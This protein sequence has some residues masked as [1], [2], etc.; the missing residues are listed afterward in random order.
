MM[1]L[2]ASFAEAF[3]IA[4]AS[5]RASKLRSF[6]TLLGIILSTTTLI[7]VM[8]VIHGMNRYVAEKIADLG[9]GGFVVVRMAFFG[10]FD[11]KKFLEMLRKN[12]QLKVEEFE[13]IK[14]QATLVHDMG[15]RSSRT[16]DL[17]AGGIRE[18]E[19]QITGGST[20][21]NVLSNIQTESGRYF[22]EPENFNRRT[23]AFIGSDIKDRF[24]T[25]VDPI[26]KTLSIAGRPYTVI[27]V[28]KRMGSVF[29]QSQDN[30]V[31]IPI[32][33]FFKQYTARSGLSFAVQAIDQDHTQQAMDEVRVLMRSYRHVPPGKE[34]NF[35]IFASDSIMSLWE[36][37]TSA[38]A[39]TAV[40]VV[41]VFM[42]VGGVVIMNIMLAVVTERTVEIG[43]RKSLGARRIDILQQFLIES[44]VLSSFGGLSGVVIAWAVA[45]I[46]RQTT[47]VP[48][49]L[50]PIAIFLGVGISAVVGLFFGIYPAHRASKLDPI[51]ALRAER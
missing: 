18:D 2:R 48:M 14:S 42:V 26:G 8:S 16:A 43:V 31:H 4:L 28:A 15:M 20:N 9:A 5:L 29:G 3:W 6:L 1:N 41:S 45:L 35:T 49:E 37:L 38:I 12:P 27:G 36:R 13:F 34:D 51:E 10:D 17:T 33:T 39:A 47:P 19:V 21:L 40:A 44:A 30:F 32:N 7:A 23:V 11:P 46:V 22:S 25:G 50:P 24:F